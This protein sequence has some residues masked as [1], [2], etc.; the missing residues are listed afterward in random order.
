MKKHAAHSSLQ[1]NLLSIFLV[2]LLLLQFNIVYGDMSDNANV[3]LSLSLMLGASKPVLDPMSAASHHFMTNTTVNMADYTLLVYM[4]GSDLESQHLSATKD[5]IEMR[6]A[7]A[8]NSSNINVIVQT[9]GG[10]G[11]PGKSPSGVE[12]FIDFTKVQRHQM[13][14]GSFHTF[15][16]LGVINM[17]EPTSL[18]DFIK[19]GV[20]NFPARNYAILL[21][22]HGSGVNGFGKDI[23]FNNS[24]LDPVELALAFLA[25]KSE[26]GAHFELI[27]FDACLMSS[28]EVA[29][30]LHNVAD[31]MVSSQEV[32]PSWGWDY[33]AIV[34][35]L[36]DDSNQ[37]GRSLGIAIADSFVKH[38][39][40]SSKLEE[41]GANKDITLSVIDLAK[42]PQLVKDVNVL[43]NALISAIY[44]LPSALNISKSID[45]TENYGRSSRA[46]S[47]LID[48][49]DLTENIQDKYPAL[50]EN[51]KA[52]QNSLKNASIY[53]I[54]GDARPNAHGISIYLPLGP[55]EFGLTKEHFA[56]DLDWLRL[57]NIQKSMITTDNQPPILKSMK[58]GDAITS[59]VYGSD[60]SSIFAQILTNSSRGDNLIYTQ[61]IEPSII[62]N[63]EFLNYNKYDMLVICNETKCIPASMNLEVNR[64]K[65]FAFI[66]VR[67]ESNKDKI[68]Q[69]ISLVYEINKGGEL[70]FLGATP[71]IDPEETIPK[72]KFSLKKDDKIFSKA[73]PARPQPQH[74]SEVIN[75]KLIDTSTYIEEGP[76]VVNDP[77]RMSADY[78]NMTSPFSISFTICDYSDNCDKT[79]WY[80]ITLSQ[81]EILPQLPLDEQFSYDLLT[82]NKTDPFNTVGNSYTYINPLFGFKLEYPSDWIRESQSIYVDVSNDYFSDPAVVALFPSQ[83]V[84][85]TGSNYRPTLSIDVTDWPFR[86]SPKY[87]FDFFNST[88]DILAGQD[89]KIVASGPAVIA[90]NPGFKFII[91][92][93]SDEEQFLGL[94]EQKRTEAIIT[95]LMNGR[96]YTISFGSYSSQFEDY[97]PVVE[98]IL[99]TFE[100]YPTSTPNPNQN[101]SNNT[102]IVLDY[103]ILNNSKLDVKNLSIRNTTYAQEE[104]MEDILTTDNQNMT[105]NIVF[106]T[107]SDEK[108]GYSIKY[109]S[110]VGLGKP[111]SLEDANPNL[112]GNLISLDNSS[113]ES[114]NPADS[115]QVTVAAFYTNE[116]DRMSRL[117]LTPSLPNHTNFNADSVASIA[118]E[119]L[120]LYKMFPDFVL[121]ENITTTLNNNPAYAVEYKYFNPIYRSQL[122]TRA[123]Y[124]LHDDR[125]LV[126]QYYSNP[127]KYY[128]YLP[129]FQE[130]INSL[131]FENRQ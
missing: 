36:I 71:E 130:M 44:D 12:R 99:N 78:I 61:N 62:D 8:E 109:P 111:F 112:V 10:G 18:S 33:Q 116:T 2:S 63:N 7:T 110:N 22:D 124:I 4:I 96:M 120:S 68:N 108:Y 126:F 34:G 13:T 46:S 95:T 83:Y 28:L 69:N 30:R 76:L 5:L 79:R 43:S 29:S 1:V 84:E 77:A 26:T 89:F 31:Y 105:A 52:V 57:L 103:G 37:S 85:V 48:L 87:L 65:R 80:S 64:D 72:S 9:G 23:L 70:V 39:E 56:V 117:I 82:E 66:P 125:F 101:Q 97:A 128:D 15:M 11:K 24:T 42:I 119:E 47:G 131:E 58:Q 21:W 98:N 102:D 114:S 32:E 92:Y 121:L 118:S 6:A 67:L 113:E 88:D 106:S 40:E 100:P 3:S 35:S 17:A 74:A 91:E 86:E 16:D 122:H 49:F 115:A 55:N 14:N 27:G 50:S 51:I 54:K 75:P 59:S 41:F 60:I 90:G 129:I 38:S 45:L 107:Y 20:L 19:W 94:A 53:T 81:E 93:I 123:I 73:L 104:P 127:S 25:A